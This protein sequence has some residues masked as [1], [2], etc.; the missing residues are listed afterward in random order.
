MKNSQFRARTT[1]IAAAGLS[2][3]VTSPVLADCC[4]SLLGCAATYVTDGVS[5]EIETVIDTL[6]AISTGITNF[7]HDLDG[8]TQGA[9]QT[10]VAS[11]NDTYNQ[12]QSQSQQS[13]SDLATA[14]SQ[15][16]ALYQ[17]ETAIKP[18]EGASVAQMQGQPLP[19]A[20]ATS[21][22]PHP[23]VAARARQPTTGGGPLL[24]VTAQGNQNLVPAGGVS[25]NPLIQKGAVDASIQAGLGPALVSTPP[26]T[27][28]DAFSRAIQQIQ[29]LKTAGDT[30]FSKV[31]ASL[32]QA[33]S[34]EASGVKAA[35]QARDVL[36]APL[37]AVESTVS[38]L[39]THPWSAWDPSSIVDSIEDKI[40]ADLSANMGAMVNDITTDADNDFAAVQP[41][42]D[43]LLATAQAAQALETAMANA[44]RQRT[45]A[46]ANALYAALPT[47][48]FA[49]MDS[50]STTGTGIAANNVDM[51]AKFGA[52]VPFSAIAA[53]YST[54]QQR[55]KLAYKP[56]DTYRLHVAITQFKAQRAQGKV[57]PQATLAAYKSKLAQQFDG[58]LNGRTPA[59]IASQ[60]DQLISE[61]R[62]QFAKDP[63]TGSAVIGLLNS[64]ASRRMSTANAATTN[65]TLPG[66]PVATTT[67]QRSAL[68]ATPP[69]GLTTP[70]S[71]VNQSMSGAAGTPSALGAA[72][73]SLGAP[74]L[75]SLAPGIASQVRA[76]PG[77]S[78][79]G[80]SSPGAVAGWTRPA[81]AT[82]PAMTTRAT[83]AN[84]TIP[85]QPVSPVGQQVAPVAQPVNQTKAPVWG[86]APVQGWTP[87]AAATAPVAAPA[88]NSLSRFQ[89]VKPLQQQTQPPQAAPPTNP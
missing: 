57:M 8:Q 70:I 1:A 52:R 7:I 15:A 33:Q 43:E 36:D 60:R 50:K 47:R 56:P 62:S 82:A 53:H 58:T 40:K 2:L 10:A 24:A 65:P 89:T 11:V 68:R 75:G 69:A 83:L 86:T 34:S 4:S 46:A 37:V 88:T 76:T 79:P 64:E 49:G 48:H 18:Y 12:M 42:Y 28:A 26:G 59:A 5:C 61:A 71:S 81:A 80:T 73:S 21:A 72:P 39:L 55:A 19:S 6:N 84:P 87:P 25:N 32:Q 45:P 78:A 23:Q 77:V 51:A 9:I 30:D 20:S 13:D 38:D 27:F 17:Q 67:G 3:A 63:N 31:N 41:N 14:L 16:T 54:A 74:S 29:V 44:Y 66:Q 85:G 22:P 35:N